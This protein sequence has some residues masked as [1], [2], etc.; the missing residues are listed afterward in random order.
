MIYL[1]YNLIRL[2]LFEGGNWI[3]MITV[4]TVHNT[5]FGAWQV[6]KEMLAE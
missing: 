1:L 6:H 2:E 5:D 4:D 3:L